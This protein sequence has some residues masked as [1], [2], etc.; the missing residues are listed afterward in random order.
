MSIYGYDQGH[1]IEYIY[2]PPGRLP[3]AAC[4]P[5]QGW[6]LPPFLSQSGLKQDGERDDRS[7]LASIAFTTHTI[8][9]IPVN[10]ATDDCY[11]AIFIVRVGC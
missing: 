10:S 7:F 5:P 3:Y 9:L 8:R 1:Y 6:I 2:I 4:L 11:D